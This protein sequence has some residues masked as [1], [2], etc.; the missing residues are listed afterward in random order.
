MTHFEWLM[1][2]LAEPFGDECVEW[3]FSKTPDGYGQVSKDYKN[4]RPNR[5][6][7]ATKSTPPN[8]RCHAAHSCGNR[9][10]FNPKHLRWASPKENCADKIAH[11]THLKGEKIS[12]AKLTNEQV[13][14]MRRLYNT[15]QATQIELAY[16]FGVTM[17]ATNRI[18]CG[19]S[20][21]EG[22]DKR[23]FLARKHKYRSPRHFTKAQIKDICQRYRNGEA[24]GEIAKSFDMQ[25]ATIGRVLK[26]E[27]LK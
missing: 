1:K 8:N 26:R 10:C 18:L 12:Q 6:A 5:I 3:P 20:Y 27:G 7:C 23:A 21:T 9:S 25:S 24:Q 2:R 16:R 17:A 14:E 4:L 13:A 11:G 15:N 19:K 22:F